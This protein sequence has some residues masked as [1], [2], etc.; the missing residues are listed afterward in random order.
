MYREHIC[1]YVKQSEVSSLSLSTTNIYSAIRPILYRHP[2]ITSFT[3]LT[4]FNRTLTQATYLGKAD[5][6]WSTRD[7]L[8]QTRFLDITLDPTLDSARNHGQPP[9]AILIS[10]ILQSIERR[11][12]NVNITLSFT[13][14]KCDSTPISVL[15][16]ESY[17][18]VKELVICVGNHDPE[19]TH[20]RQVSHCAPNAKFWRPLVDGTTFPDC[21][22]LEVRHHWAIPPHERSCM[23]LSQYYSASS[24]DLPEMVLPRNGRF[25]TF[26]AEQPLY[27]SSWDVIGTTDGLEKFESISLE[28]TPELSPSIMMQLFGDQKSTA[29]N[30][31]TLELRFCDLGPNIIAVLL[32]HIPPN[33]SRLVLLCRER[34]R[35]DSDPDSDYGMEEKPTHL[36]PLLRQV[37]KSLAHLEYGAS[38]ICRELFFDK[39][40]IESLRQDGIMTKVGQEGGANMTV[41]HIDA[42]AIQETVRRCRQRTRAA[43]HQ[44]HFNNGIVKAQAED[45]S[46]ASPASVFGGGS[47]PEATA[48][49]SQRENAIAR[50]KE[51]E[52]RRRLIDGSKIKWFRR[53][54]AWGG[55]CGHGDTW[56]E[57]DVAANMEEEGITWVLASR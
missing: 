47:R 5:R 28:A 36:C 45:T 44:R 48:A 37:G 24:N 15:G 42:H 6:K 19:E 12:P 8:D 52:Q 17:P 27:S 43:F 11:C 35:F 4:L 22:S 56:E 1:L 41:N 18:R 50:D 7:S 3:S 13:H 55:L 38:E 16:Q 32:H 25:P 40:E 39:V 21:K 23:D 53:L 26:G 14:C 29:A 2:K 30:L 9:P 34:E 51:G 10:R 49:K 46:E 33:L 20:Q 31:R 54:V 57:M